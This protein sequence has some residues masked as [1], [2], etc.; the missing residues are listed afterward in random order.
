MPSYSPTISQ[1]IAVKVSIQVSN[2]SCSDYS[3]HINE[4]NKVFII[5]I[6]LSIDNSFNS[7]FITIDSSSTHCGSCNIHENSILYL[8]LLNLE[9]RLFAQESTSSSSSD[10]T[11]A[12]YIQVSASLITL[13]S[14][15]QAL[16]NTTTFANYLKSTATLYALPA[17]A[18]TRV[19]S[20]VSIE[21]IS[22]TYSPT[23]V[24]STSICPSVLPSY[25]PSMSS[26]SSSSSSKGLSTGEMSHENTVHHMNDHNDCR[27][28][29]RDS[30]G[31]NF[32]WFNFDCI[33][34][35]FW[36]INWTSSDSSRGCRR[37]QTLSSRRHSHLNIISF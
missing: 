4:Y 23:S 5:S 32:G 12:Y 30:C 14:L 6:A 8:I 24:P 17:L 26:S 18:A 37:K 7:S 1:I 27:V 21:N 36:I 3:N 15:T 22:P 34:S 2:V 33:A 16:S 9:R 20:M 25:L 28:D 19:S 11:L 29:C 13:E 35:L 10:L 31:L